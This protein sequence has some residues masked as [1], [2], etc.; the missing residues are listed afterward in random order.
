VRIDAAAALAMVVCGALAIA[1]A[2]WKR[3][4]LERVFKPLTTLLL[5]P[6]LGW[7]HHALA[8]WVAVG[9][10]LSLAGD[11]ALLW[12]TERAFLRG[13][14]AFFA[15]H[16]AYIAGFGSRGRCGVL[17]AATLAAAVMITSGGLHLLWPRIQGLRLP[18]LIYAIAVSGMVVSAAAVV[19]SAPPW[20]W[21]ALPGAALFYVSDGCLAWNRF[22]RPIRRAPL[23]T[24]GLYWLGQGAIALASRAMEAR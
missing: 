24:L 22:V 4:L 5:L 3:P 19:T 9:I 1:G 2:S 13:M 11:V 7:P 17:A 6:L 21:L 16:L 15:T 8:R 10:C 14:A 23:V 20:S 18:I 12:K